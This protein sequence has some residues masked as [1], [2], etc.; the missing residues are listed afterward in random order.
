MVPPPDS[1][2]RHF[3]PW[4]RP[5]LPQAV[6]WLAQDWLGAGPLDLSRVLVIVPTRQSGRRL[7]EALAEHAAAR[8]Q[9][10]FPP[11]V[12]TPEVL[13]RLRTPGGVASRF[14]SQLAWAAVLRDLD[15]A[16]VREVFPVDPPSRDFAWARRLGQQL[17]QVQALLAEG[18]LRIA[19][20]GAAAGGDFPEAGRW[21]QLATLEN[22]HAEKLTSLG[23]RDGPA[24]QIAAAAAPA[25]LEGGG[26][27]VLL[28]TPDPLPLA[29]VALAQHAQTTP[30]DIVVYAP[31][32]ESAAFDG[33]GRPLTAVWNERRLALPDFAQRVQ[34]CADPAAQVER[35]V[36]FARAQP[37]PETVLAIGVADPEVTPL[38]ERELARADIA[39]FNPEGSPRRRDALYAL[40]AALAEF[41]REP[42]FEAVAVLVRCPDVLAWLAGR[43]GGNFSAARVLRELDELR[44]RHLPATL[45][46]AQRHTAGFP[47]AED[48]LA[49]LVELRGVLTGGEF[50]ANAA[51][52]LKTIFAQRTFAADSPPA[53]SAAAWT[54]TLREA[55]RALARFGGMATA[56]GWDF[57]L[58]EFAELVRPSE[59]P[60]G[61][62][63]LLGW[64]EL[65]WEDAP[66]LVVAGVNEGFVPKAIVGDAF[67]PETLRVR[68]GLKTNAT[69]AACDAYLLTAIAA[70]RR[71]AAG[72]LD[73]LVGKTSAAGEPLRPSRLLLRCPDEE[74]PT[75]VAQLFQAAPAARS[76]PPWTR[77]WRLRPRRTEAPAHVAVTALRSYLE[78]PFRFYLGEVL[79]LERVDPAKAELAA[80][81]FGIL[82]HAALQQ[83]GED[84]ALHDCADAAVLRDFLLERFEVA[85]RA[86]YGRELTLPLVIQLESARQRLRAA[87]AVEAQERAA[88]WRT[89]RVEW[90]FALPL[91]GL[92]LRGKIDRI[93][94]HADGRVRVLD[95]KTGDRAEA[96]AA[97]HLRAARAADDA[98]PAWR[99]CTDTTGK[100]RVWTDLQL[101]LYRLAVRREFGDAVT[102][103]YFDLPKATGET[104]V[105]PWA[106][107]TRELQAAAEACA[108]GA[109]AAIAAGEFWPPAEYRGREAEWDEFAELFHRGAAASIA[110]EDTTP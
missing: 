63:D 72:R 12:I 45:A 29:L 108:A 38:L 67:L 103:G 10:A 93:D 14:E 109:V 80:S 36:H 102:C 4:D 15:L 84:V 13:L 94:R 40:L 52:A 64:L 90:K 75:R 87:A 96:P 31:P 5:L 97:K 50:P 27:I 44:A 88:G 20:V 85:A 83:L 101:P 59:R 61:A 17:A 106:D 98:L 110:W 100:P 105:A 28:A 32:A 34:L 60:A 91:G 7:R 54:E 56:E 53:E 99:R 47:V 39:A 89:V 48:A 69:R 26:R 35:V 55:G 41:A 8:G 21:A 95:Y 74:L 18:G 82:V 92:E 23:L 78:C 107:L 70:W 68:L 58:G 86:R 71:G 62:L 81:D 49:A 3:L 79:A 19:D 9:A 37:A 24:A 76:S 57:A 51:A 73:L 42:D 1:L 30:V 6:A 104:A 16:T 2:R 25:A 33:W 46:A 43:G 11:R 66:H 22:H 65:L 77:A